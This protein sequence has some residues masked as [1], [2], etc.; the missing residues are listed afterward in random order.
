MAKLKVIIFDLDYTLWPFWVDTHVDPPFKKSGSKI[1]DSRGKTIKC[2]SEVP[3]V[4]EI[5]HK[6]GYTLAVA[7]RTSEIKGARQLIDLF[8]WEKYFSVKEIFPGCKVTHINNIKK[9]T[10]AN[11]EEMLFFD[12][13]QRNIFDL[14]KIGVASILVKDGV[15]KK[16]IEESLPKFLQKSK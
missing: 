15:N 3:Q 4:L 13:E 1:V 10:G 2:Y 11:Y 9:Q 12:D 6:Q 16:V 14:T 7:S 5:L 8:G